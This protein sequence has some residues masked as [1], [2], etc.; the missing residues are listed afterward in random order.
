MMMFEFSHEKV[1]MLHMWIAFSENKAFN[2]KS[3]LY[4]HR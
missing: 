1:P 3:L 4:S 2:L